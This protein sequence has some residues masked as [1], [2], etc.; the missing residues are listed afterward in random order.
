HENKF[1]GGRD[2]AKRMDN[3]CK[4]SENLEPV[5]N[6]CH[7]GSQLTELQPIKEAVKIMADLVRNSKAIKIELSFIDIGGGLGIIYK[8]EK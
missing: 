3:Q 2:T 4:D 6:H 5:G 7:I 8:D 1:G